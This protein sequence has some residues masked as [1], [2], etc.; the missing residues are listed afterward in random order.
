MTPK[1]KKERKKRR[2]MKKRIQP[3]YKRRPKIVKFLLRKK[4]RNK[5]KNR[6]LNRLPILTQEVIT[7]NDNLRNLHLKRTKIF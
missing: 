5:N 2:K 3:H 4:F 7:Q 1:K 6:K